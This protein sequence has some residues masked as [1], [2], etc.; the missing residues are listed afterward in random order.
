MR[1]NL[2]ILAG[3]SSTLTDQLKDILDVVAR[4][5][6]RGNASQRARREKRAKEA[7]RDA[8]LSKEYEVLRERIQAGLWHDGR[9]DAI[10]GNGVMSEL[11]VGIEPFFDA[12]ADVRAASD[13]ESYDEK[14]ATMSELKQK[15]KHS[16]DTHAVEFMPVVIVK[17]FETRGGGS[18]REELLNV[19]AQW[20][21]TLAE[22]QVCREPSLHA[23][24]GD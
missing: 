22:N 19:L 16:E 10:C 9:I 20:A 14:G 11:G 23:R 13:V 8:A 3:L 21:A 6:S 24:Q 17:G 7:E 15:Q 18:R 1:L 4:G 2:F 12:D 5:L